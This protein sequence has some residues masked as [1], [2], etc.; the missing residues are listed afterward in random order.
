MYEISHVSLIC[1]NI[2]TNVLAAGLFKISHI[3]YFV[4]YSVDQDEMGQQVWFQNTFH[5]NHIEGTVIR[6]LPCRA[7]AA[8]LWSSPS[9][10][11]FS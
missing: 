3:L 5:R 7:I 2:K 11:D 10:K 4:T 6:F 9:K 8:L 1:L